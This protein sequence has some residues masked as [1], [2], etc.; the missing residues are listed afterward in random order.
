MRTCLKLRLT[1][2]Y[3]AMSPMLTKIEGLV[4]HTNTGKATRLSSYYHHWEA[5]IYDGIRH[6]SSSYPCEITSLLSN[7]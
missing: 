3:R 2:S 7:I 4:V 6:V 1:T 5:R